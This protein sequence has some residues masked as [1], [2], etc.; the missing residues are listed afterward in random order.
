MSAMDA[1]SM[2][3]CTHILFRCLSFVVYKDIF[4][5]K[6]RITRGFISGEGN[7]IK[8]VFEIVSAMLQDIVI[9]LGSSGK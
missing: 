9:I 8:I 3:L 1:L 7:D 5:V 6:L 4:I 2:K